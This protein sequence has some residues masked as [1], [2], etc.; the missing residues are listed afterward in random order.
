[1]LSKCGNQ[2]SER[3][4][5]HDMLGELVLSPPL[6][7]CLVCVGAL[8]LWGFDC[9]DVQVAILP[10]PPSYSYHVWKVHLRRTMP[11]GLLVAMASRWTPAGPQAVE[12]NGQTG[13]GMMGRDFGRSVPTEGG[14]CMFRLELFIRNTKCL[15]SRSSQ[16]SVTWKVTLLHSHSWQAGWCTL[17]PGLG[18]WWFIFLSLLFGINVW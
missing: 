7:R 12:M 13:A 16:T 8:S 17:R 18:W 15:V 3:W 5:A 14:V 6:P 9:D 11:C 2:D 4:S 10:L 1:M